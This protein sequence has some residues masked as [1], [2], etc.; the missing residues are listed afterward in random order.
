[1]QF[2]TEP[3]LKVILSK[4]KITFLAA[5][6]LLLRTHFIMN[7]YLPR[8]FIQ[9]ILFIVFQIHKLDQRLTVS[10]Y[11]CHKLPNLSRGWS[12]PAQVHSSSNIRIFFLQIR[13]KAPLHI[14]WNYYVNQHLLLCTGH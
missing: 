10:Q 9:K 4:R 6:K 1:M 5:A 12:V 3:M 11:F 14:L 2:G 8:I 13:R 7:G